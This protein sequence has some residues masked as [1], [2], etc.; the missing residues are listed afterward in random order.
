[1]NDPYTV[2]GLPAEADDEAIRQRYLELVR[3][4]TPEENAERFAAVR[5]AYE[6]LRD[7]DSRVRYRLFEQGKYESI[8]SIS[9]E[10]ECQTPRLRFSLATL[11]TLRNP[12]R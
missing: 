10:L 4:Y 5:A 1:M 6:Q 11:L 9:K 12:P 3:Q 7:L 2:L 8:D